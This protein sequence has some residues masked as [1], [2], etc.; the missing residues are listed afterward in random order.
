MLRAVGDR[1]H[2]YGVDMSNDT[3]ITDTAY[4][5]VVVIVMWRGHAG[6]ASPDAV[7]SSAMTRSWSPWTRTVPSVKVDS[8][9]G[10]DS[11]HNYCLG[12]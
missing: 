3:D 5:R 1:L 7:E 10:D 2:T 8:A 12:S 6:A 9:N 11:S 4:A